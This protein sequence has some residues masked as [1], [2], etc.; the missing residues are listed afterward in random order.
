MASMIICGIF[1]YYIDI[2][3]NVIWTIK[4]QHL[5]LKGLEYLCRYGIALML[6][7]RIS[8]MT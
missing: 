5:L 7:F 3:L 6:I 8:I 2:I 4:G 1:D